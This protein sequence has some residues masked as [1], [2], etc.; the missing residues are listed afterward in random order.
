MAYLPY[1]LSTMRNSEHCILLDS[2]VTFGSV[3]CVMMI[4]SVSMCV[5][6]A[7][8]MYIVFARVLKYYRCFQ[9][10][11]YCWGQPILLCS[12]SHSVSL[13]KQHKMTMKMRVW[14][15][16]ERVRY[17]THTHTLLQLEFSL[18]LSF[19]LGHTIPIRSSC[20]VSSCLKNIDHTWIYTREGNE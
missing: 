14:Q 10:V 16:K 8:Y 2:Y 13:F 6:I 12:H 15:R 11:L 9:V 4:V 5:C 17:G 20:L 7:M 3:C 18:P 19:G 1:T